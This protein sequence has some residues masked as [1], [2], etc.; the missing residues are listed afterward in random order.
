[1]IRGILD[2]AAAL[3]GYGASSET[4]PLD[5]SSTEIV[6]LPANAGPDEPVTVCFFWPG[7]KEVLTKMP[8]YPQP[9]RTVSKPTFRVGEAGSK[10]LGLFAA[11]ALGQGELIIDE[12]PLLISVRG[13][14]VAV[15]IWYSQEQTTKYQLNLKE[16]EKYLEVVLKE[17]RPAD[18]DAF[19]SLANSHT[20]DGSGPIAGRIRTN[21][22]G[23][24]G[25][26]PDMSGPMAQ[27]S[28]VPHFISRM[29]NR[30]VFLSCCPNTS[31]NFHDA[32]I[33]YTIYAARDIAEGEEL[34]LAY[35]D[36][37]D[38]AANRQQTFKP[39]GF[40]CACDACLDPINS[41]TRRAKIRSFI[42]TVQLWAVNRS[43]PDDWLINKCLEQ[44]ALLEQEKLEG[45]A[46]YHAAIN[47]IMEAYICLGNSPKVRH[48]AAR[49][50]KCPWA[51]NIYV[52]IAL[53]SHSRHPLWR[54]RQAKGRNGVAAQAER[55][56]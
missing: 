49:A 36:V 47:A 38:T 52:L 30:H 25:L 39:Y 6:V 8:G 12:R 13:V 46:Q 9:L 22:I 34:T 35:S 33:S 48:W 29:N 28:S 41:D 3:L 42:P 32:S 37:W 20:T 45:E 54:M 21:S 17:M 11:R 14:P 16:F 24:D 10:G 55:K 19:M 2:G 44:I 15:P 51:A 5:F 50:R 26:C 4:A 56:I 53:K 7:S 31:T 27:Y 43:L 40:V 1:M 18:R 23:L